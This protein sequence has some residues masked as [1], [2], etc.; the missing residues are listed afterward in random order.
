MLAPYKVLL[1]DMNN[2]FMFDEDRFSPTQDYYLIYKWVEGQGL[3]A[4]EVNRYMTQCYDRIIADYT[5]PA[6]VEDFP[7]VR[8]VLT[9]LGAP[10]EQLGFLEETFAHY[11]Q[12][13]VP[14]EYTEMLRL[15]SEHFR[16]GLICNLW[17]PKGH[18][19]DYLTATGI[20]DLFDL[21]VFSSD[22][23]FMKPSPKIFHLALEHFQIDPSRV[24]HIGDSHH[25]DVC[26]AHN[27][28]IDSIWIQHDQELPTTGPSPTHIIKNLLTLKE[29]LP[30]TNKKS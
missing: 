15:L 20:W 10:P 12:G 8:D 13:H 7:Q 25:H 29:Y 17:A 6:K 22:Y 27:S 21:L 1:L 14:A 23:N 9:E 28:G 2:T 11:E 19:Q 16:L 26:G 3:S 18:W 4:E 5:N 24:V 30:Q